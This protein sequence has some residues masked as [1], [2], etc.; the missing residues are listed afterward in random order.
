M[1]GFA[2]RLH[3]YAGCVPFFHST[4]F[5]HI[6]SGKD[7]KE[8]PDEVLFPHACKWKNLAVHSGGYVNNVIAEY[9]FCD[10]VD[11]QRLN[12]LASK[13]SIS[14]LESIKARILLLRM[15]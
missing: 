8:F 9:I 1:T 5:W 2:N 10:A 12:I 7:A 13:T 6:L 3:L 4:V 14:C 11:S 15:L